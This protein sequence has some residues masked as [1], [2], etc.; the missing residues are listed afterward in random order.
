MPYGTIPYASE[1]GIFCGLAGNSNRR[2]GKFSPSSGN[3]ALVRYFGRFAPADKSDRSDRSRTG[4]GAVSR[5]VVRAGFGCP[6]TFRSAAGALG[7]AVAHHF[8][9]H[10]PSVE[11][12]P[13]AKPVSGVALGWPHRQHGPQQLGVGWKPRGRPHPTRHHRAGWLVGAVGLEPNGPLIKSRLL[14]SGSETC[15]QTRWVSDPR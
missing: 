12:I 13:L 10:S 9:E 5:F 7:S 2:S 6:Q 3:P 1:Q 15:D 4:D 11:P 14:P 8:V